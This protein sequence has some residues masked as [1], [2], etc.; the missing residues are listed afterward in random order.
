[1]NLRTPVW[2][3]PEQTSEEVAVVD[4]SGKLIGVT[5]RRF[6]IAGLLDAK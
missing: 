5:S 6:L 2:S 1:M 4:S 3:S